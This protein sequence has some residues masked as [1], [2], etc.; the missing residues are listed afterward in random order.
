MTRRWCCPAAAAGE[1]DTVQFNHI[2]IVSISEAPILSTSAV[3]FNWKA[4]RQPAS[5]IGLGGG[6]SELAKPISFH[7]HRRHN[8]SIK[9]IESVG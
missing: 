1:K 2:I 4:G 6:H 8:H 7:N 5:E 3:M 9:A